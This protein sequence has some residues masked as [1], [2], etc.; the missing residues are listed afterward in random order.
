MAKDKKPA[1][2]GAPAGGDVVALGSS[3]CT[4]DGCKKK[5]DRA[6]FCNEHYDWFKAG[7]INKKGQ[8]PTDFDKKYMA[9]MGRKKAA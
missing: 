3:Q 8:K 4:A 6:G 7:L 9:F 2:G 1:G 5:S